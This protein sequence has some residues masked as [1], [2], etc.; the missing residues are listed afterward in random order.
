MRILHLGQHHEL[1]GGAEVHREQ[2]M[3]GLTRRGHGNAFFGTS[4]SVTLRRPDRR[5]VRRPGY[6]PE[7]LASDWRLQRELRQCIAEF[8]PQLIHVH[9]IPGLPLELYNDLAATGL[10]VVETVYDYGLLCTNSWAVHGDGQPCHSTPGAEC[11]RNACTR[12]YPFNPGSVLAASARLKLVRGAVDVAIAPTEHLRGRLQAAGLKEVV[13]LPYFPAAEASR[14]AVGASDP[15]GREQAV[16]VVARLE[17]EKGV[18][19]LLEAFALLAGRRPEVRLDIIGSG[20]QREALA[21]RA[22]HLGL[23][24]AVRFLGTKNLEQVRSH[25]LKARVLALPS[26]WMEALPLVTFDANAAGLPMVAHAIGGLPEAVLPGING[27]LVPVAAAAE[28]AQALERVLTDDVLWARLSRGAI[29]RSRGFSEEQ[30]LDGIESAYQRALS[31]ARRRGHAQ[32]PVMDED[33]RVLLDAV[34]RHCGSMEKELDS[35]QQ[36]LAGRLVRWQRRGRRIGRKLA[37]RWQRLVAGPSP[38]SAAPGPAV[39]ESATSAGVQR[40]AAPYKLPEGASEVTASA[41]QGPAAVTQASP[42]VTQAPKA[43]PPVPAALSQTARFPAPH[44]APQSLL[45]DPLQPDPSGQG[46][47]TG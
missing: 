38:A 24:S 32:A 39:A 46:R 18:A 34:L 6:D 22:A 44:R 26:I 42:G 10:P 33:E 15:Q 13:T 14:V 35:L 47:A 23:T 41:G 2:V 12:N 37:E 43:Q 28:M 45:E 5:V 21:A 11:F 16:L 19:E 30:H 36:G 17:R 8:E 4:P 9:Q 27:L 40:P 20:P 3:A 1:V 25:M 7:R 31:L 29:E